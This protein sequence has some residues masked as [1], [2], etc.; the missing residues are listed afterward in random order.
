MQALVPR[1][2]W[3]LGT[4]WSRDHI[5]NTITAP[6][7]ADGRY[8]DKV[9][10]GPQSMCIKVDLGIKLEILPVV[11][12]AGC[13]DPQAEP[14]C[15]FRPESNQWEDGYAFPPETAVLEERPQRRQLYPVHQGL[16]APAQ[17]P[18]P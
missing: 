1:R 15:L 8:C 10:Y 13:N 12:K 14:F 3:R 16:Q 7:L 17:L 4:S 2:G 5:F 18:P 6:L 9:R 11:Y